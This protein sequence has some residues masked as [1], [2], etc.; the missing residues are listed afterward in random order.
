M[1]NSLDLA[2]DRD[3]EVPLG[4]QLI[5]KLRT[6]IS[7]GTLAPG[8]R[9]PGLR[10]FAEAAGVNVNTVRSVIAKLEEQG[11]LSSEQ[12]RG[13]FVAA[14]ARTDAALAAAASAAFEAA[15]EAGVDPRQLAAALY[16]SQPESLASERTQRRE[17]YRELGRLERELGR[18]DPLSALSE[19]P[20]DVG[21]RI[22]SLAE[23]RRTREQ[24][25][26]R[27]QEL[28]EETAQWRLESEAAEREAAER[29][30]RPAGIRRL[31]AWHGAGV[32]TGRPG[33]QVSWT[34]G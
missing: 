5:W 25:L 24:L 14:T 20:P 19:R 15:R 34:S 21:A 26:H 6:L 33:A 30:A 32:W 29:S 17:L 1:A 2:L 12:G 18:L 10:E 22:L 13:T 27:I 9:L 4:T 28:H 16:V 7:D 23:L 8:M 11:V 31:G 3:S